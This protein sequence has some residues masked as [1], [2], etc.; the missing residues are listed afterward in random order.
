M[1]YLIKEAPVKFPIL[2]KHKFQLSDEACDLIRKVK[3]FGLTLAINQGLEQEI[4]KLW[5]G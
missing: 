2:E 3:Q 1:Y 4:G 5:W